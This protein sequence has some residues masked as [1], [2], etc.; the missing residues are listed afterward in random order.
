MDMTM[1]RSRISG[2]R[3]LAWL[4]AIGV[5]AAIFLF[6]SQPADE[7]TQVSNWVIELMVRAAKLLGFGSAGPERMEEFFELLSFP[8]RKCAHM[9]E[10]TILFSTLL[11]AVGGWRQN[12][13]RCLRTAFLLTVMYA[14]TDEFHQLFVPGRAGRVTDVMIDSIGAL[15][16]TVMLWGKCNLRQ[17]DS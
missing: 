8:V 15:V 3:V 11:L 5:A 12:R 7:S 10:Y 16:L 17:E 9:T 4:P 13:R 2:K 6:S 14:C 1:S